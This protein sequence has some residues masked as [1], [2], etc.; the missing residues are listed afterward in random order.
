MAKKLLLVDDE[1]FFLEGLNEGLSEY[2]DIFTTDICFSVKEAITL[3][4][5]NHYDLIISDIRMPDHSG[6]EFFVY[7]RKQNYKGGCIAMTAYGSPEVIEKIKKVGGLDIILKPF[8]F[9]WFKDKIL[10]FFAEEQEGVTGVIDSIAL[11]SLLQMIN[12]EKKS[13]VVKVEYQNQQGFLYFDKGEIIHAEYKE[14]E[15]ELAAFHLI[16]MNKGR[17]SILKPTE[18]SIPE[19]TITTPFMV[20]LMNA[21]K[22]AD[23]KQKEKKFENIMKHHKMEDKMDI[24]KLEEAVDYLKE[25]IGKG[26]IHTAI[27]TAADG[28]S[29]V[30]YNH[31]PRAVAL[32]NHLTEEITNSLNQSEEEFAQLGRYYLID[33]VGDNMTIILDLGEYQWG[34][35]FDK[36]KVQLGLLLNVVIP[37]LIDRI[38]DAITGDE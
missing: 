14:E 21:M 8:D 4:N 32:F 24:S 2:E 28:Q 18:K 38:E 12:L 20:L 27:W 31:L 36:K 35:L 5:E 30:T 19:K 13:L 37:S 16:G 6:L 33:L 17:F 23:E 1:K 7:L 11:T 22:S 34:I 9:A 3:F 10:D 25:K 15:G 26:L 29:L